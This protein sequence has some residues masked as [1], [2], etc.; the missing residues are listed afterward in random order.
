MRVVRQVLAG[1]RHGSRD[2][3]RGASRRRDVSIGHK[4]QVDM[5]IPYLKPAS[6][7]YEG[8]VSSVV[9]HA[10]GTMWR[11]SKSPTGQ[12]TKRKR[13]PRKRERGSLTHVINQALRPTLAHLATVNKRLD[14]G[15]RVYNA[16]VGESLARCKHM[17][18][19]PTFNAAKAMP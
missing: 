16:C 19:D 8:P 10:Y 18:A 11:V 13:H 7:V 17:R 6:R 15:R 1:F 2:N 5:K 3:E 12:A 14:A 9:I 4:Y